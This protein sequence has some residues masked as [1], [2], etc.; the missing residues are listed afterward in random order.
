M[1]SKNST[2]KIKK[3][4]AEI[5]AI[6]FGTSALGDMPDTYTYSV[7]ERRAVDTVIAIL[8]SDCPFIDCSRNYGM[9]RSETRIGLAIRELGGLPPGAIISTKLDRNMDTLEFDAAQARRSIEESLTALGVD[10][11]D[12]LHLHDPEHAA[13]LDPIIG[14]GGAIDALFKMRDE[15][16]CSA[17]GLA[18]GDVQVM[19]PILKDHDFDALVTHNRFTLVN[20]NAG[21]MIDFAAARDIAVLNAAPYAGGALAKGSGSYRRY[22][23]QEATDEVLA[24]IRQVEQ[25]CERHNVPP[26]A[27][28]LQFSMRDARI[29][30]TICG[31]SKPERVAETLAWAEYDIPDEVWEAL[32]ALPR[33]TADPEATREYKPG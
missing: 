8:S 11:V 1:L 33:T 18:A 22:V 5:P 25:I 15:G 12:I 7:D 17:V 29:T 16:L 26:G 32:S 13:S 28:A 30:S 10:R 9:G 14:S 31:V 24:P 20:D 3:T 21:A 2:M 6:C 23:Y 4:C 27:A 19:M